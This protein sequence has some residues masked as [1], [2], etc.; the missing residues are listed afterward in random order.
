MR[1]EAFAGR[2]YLMDRAA[3]PAL[4][5]QRFLHKF[6]PLT[7]LPDHSCSM[8]D[9]QSRRSSVRSKVSDN[10]PSLIQDGIG[11]GGLALGRGV[12]CAAERG[13]FQQI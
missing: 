8:T 6:E 5:E 3:G 4:I 7:V 13:R 12:K 9:L 10:R 2:F 11:H 1:I